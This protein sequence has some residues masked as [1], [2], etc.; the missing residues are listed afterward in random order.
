M[1][2]YVCNKLIQ[3]LIA[4]KKKKLGRMELLTY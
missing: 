3:I 1:D 2:Y 4:L